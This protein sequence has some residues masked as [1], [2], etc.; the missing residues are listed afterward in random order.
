METKNNSHSPT[1]K[2]VSKG[3]IFSVILL[4]TILA[5]MVAARLDAASPESFLLFYSN[6]IQ[7]ETEPCG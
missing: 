4:V 3:I 7:G 2:L 5:P 1:G 6:N